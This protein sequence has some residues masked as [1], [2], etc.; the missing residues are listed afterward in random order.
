MIPSGLDA[1]GLDF[2]PVRSVTTALNH[3]TAFSPLDL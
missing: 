2:S 1:V 3:L